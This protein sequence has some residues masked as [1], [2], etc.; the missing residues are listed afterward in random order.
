MNGKD[1]R[2]FSE[3]CYRYVHA[4]PEFDKVL[5][6]YFQRGDMMVIPRKK[7][8]IVIAE[9]AVKYHERLIHIIVHSPKIP[10]DTYVYKGLDVAPIDG[11][12]LQGVPTST[13]TKMSYAIEWLIS[14]KK[15]T[16]YVY[17]IKIE[18]GTPC[19]YIG[20]N[21]T[22]DISNSYDRIPN[23]TI[24]ENKFD[25]VRKQNELILP[26][27]IFK[28][29][30][31]HEKDMSR[32]SES[33]LRNYGKHYIMENLKRLLSGI[34]N[35]KIP[36]KQIL[37]LSGW[38]VKILTVDIQKIPVMT[39]KT[40]KW[41]VKSVNLFTGMIMGRMGDNYVISKNRPRSF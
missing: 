2:N 34:K 31:E 12:V 30:R 22:S 32:L 28:V 29:V 14:R 24:W 27:C 11:S 20:Y 18:K 25:C 3:K 26:P 33:E 8:T 40:L 37:N 16:K 1:W 41:N 23:I 21:D 19:L 39:F 17:K 36:E 10:K 7:D 5:L 38:K 35:E 13:S 15:K 4:L 9:N 6:R